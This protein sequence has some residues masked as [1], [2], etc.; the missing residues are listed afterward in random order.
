MVFIVKVWFF[1]VLHVWAFDLEYGFFIQL[2]YK[3]KIFY[4]KTMDAVKHP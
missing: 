1:S 2:F 4:I 3:E